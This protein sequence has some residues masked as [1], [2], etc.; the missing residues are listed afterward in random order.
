MAAAYITS[1]DVDAMIGLDVRQSLFTTPTVAYSSTHFDR[2]VEIASALVKSAAKN[3]GYTLGD[4]TT[5]DLVKVATLAE[6][7]KIAPA[8]RKGITVGKAFI[9]QYGGTM[10]AIRNGSLPLATAPDAAAGVAGSEF[11]STTGTASATN[12]VVPPIFSRFGLRNW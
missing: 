1:T 2:V 12:N 4:T 8:N 6:F 10:E 3:A 5:D 11:S 9:E 7:L